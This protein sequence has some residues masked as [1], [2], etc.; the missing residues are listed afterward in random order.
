[1]KRNT[2][3]LAMTVVVA[4]GMLL[5]ACGSA[6]TPTAAPTMAPAATTAPTMAPAATTAPSLPYGTRCYYG[7]GSPCRDTHRVNTDGQNLCVSTQESGQPLFRRRQFRCT[8]GCRGAGCE[9]SLSGS[10]DR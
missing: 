1:M 7:A 3:Y 10:N 5:S 9:G 6:A 4:L 8:D 2:F